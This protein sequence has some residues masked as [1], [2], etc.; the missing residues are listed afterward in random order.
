MKMKRI[1]LISV[2]MT[3]AILACSA[4]SGG[5]DGNTNA[6]AVNTAPDSNEQTADNNAV[7]NDNTEDEE[8]TELENA[9]E[10]EENDS[11]TEDTGGIKSDISADSACYN[12]FYPVSQE[13]IWTYQTYF[14]GEEP[15]E[16]TIETLEVTED[17]ITSTMTFPE[18]SSTVK[19]HCGSDGLFSS[20]YAQFNFAMM[21][22]FDIDTVSYEGI[23]L[24]KEHLWEVGYSWDTSYEISISMTVEE[25][26]ID[27]VV[28]TAFTSEITAIEEV[29]VPAGTFSQAYKVDVTGNINFD[30]MGVVMDIPLETASWYVK[31]IG[32]VKSVS[33]GEFGESGVELVSIE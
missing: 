11:M 6:T 8:S 2:V 4:F 29:T 20:E 9:E 30:M 23:T 17:T 12:P 25:V 32:M 16:Y 26:A 13:H 10:S 5:N 3:L 21:P 19:W 1:L 28:V 33:T 14:E 7:S 15:T 24:P 27:T 18:F 22:G 31:D